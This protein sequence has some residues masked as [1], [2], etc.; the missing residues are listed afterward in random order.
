M[1]RRPLRRRPTPSPTPNTT[2]SL[3]ATNEEQ[4]TEDHS[5]NETKE[6][7][8][9]ATVYQTLLKI[10]QGIFQ[11]NIKDLLQF[12]EKKMRPPTAPLNLI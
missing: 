9:E 5:D 8:F 4:T 3:G 11:L 2:S 12:A 7:G 10:L 1:R 6:P